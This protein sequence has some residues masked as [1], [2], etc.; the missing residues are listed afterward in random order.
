MEDDFTYVLRKALRGQALNLQQVTELAA[1]PENKVIS[2]SRGHF[3]SHV[4]RSL[5]KVLG[6]SPDAYAAHLDYHPES[7]RL[8]YIRRLILPFNGDQVNAWLVSKGE[9]HL[10]F[11]TGNDETSAAKEIKNL[12][13]TPSAVFITHGHPDHIGGMAAFQAPLF[14]SSISGASDLAPGN[15]IRIGEITLKAVDLSGHFNPALGYLLSG[16]DRPVLVTGDAIFAGSIGGCDPEHYRDAIQRIKSALAKLDDRTV[17]LP[18]H[19]PL[20][21]VGEEKRSNPFLA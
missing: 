21:T 7:L 16:F 6:L 19:G 12:K 1:L 18:G 13:L 8:P 5:A 2:F 14:G 10:L 20:T 3:D 17:I 15:E 4:S 11:D 9:T